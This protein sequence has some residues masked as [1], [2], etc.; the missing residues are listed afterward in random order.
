MSRV[1]EFE[2]LRP[3]LFSIAYR[4]LG[5][6]A[7][8]EDAVQESWLRYRATPTE[9]VSPKAFLSA[10]VTRV[11]IDVLRSARVRREEYVGTWF[12]E[13]LLA[14]PY[15]DPERSAELADSLSMAALLLLERLSP[16][17]RAVFVLRE[18]FGFG[19]AEIA[20]AVGSSEAACRQLAVRARRHMDEG[21]PR[22]EADR[23]AQQR[24]ADRFLDAL[25]Q[26]DVEGLRELLSADAQV[27]AD[28][29]GKAPL[30]GT[31]M[32]GAENAIRFLVALMPQFLGIGGT[33]E[34][35]QINGQPGAI[36]RDRDGKVVNTW[37]I[38][39]LDGRIQAIRVV[40]NPDKL[41]HLG[42]V[43]DQWAVVREA[44]A[45]R[46]RDGEAGSGSRRD[47]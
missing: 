25:R 27:V 39:V 7:E 40:L 11:S 6:V 26:G 37:T 22:F 13:P 36:F 18:V 30:F 44:I 21:R 23:R 12:P 14:D 38:D 4:I 10:I 47:T 19:F 29:G 9:P 28:S 8:A 32:F 35:H 20:E 34:P 41:Q 2:Q 45:G 33:V 5:S 24:L 43:A 31:G 46:R 17:E 16:L 3:L 15:E 1:E 42:P